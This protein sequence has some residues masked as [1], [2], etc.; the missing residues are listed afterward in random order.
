MTLGFK[1]KHFVSFLIILACIS[2]FIFK[3]F[4]KP[5]QYYTTADEGIYFERSMI[6]NE[7]GLNG[8]SKITNDFISIEQQHYT[9]NPCRYLYYMWGALFVGLSPTIDSLSILSLFCFFITGLILY[10]YIKK[11]ENEKIAFFASIIAITF[12]ISM[13]MAGRALM[14]SGNTLFCVWVLL[15]YALAVK[16]PNRNN[17]IIF[18]I[19]SL[20]SFFYKES[21]FFVAPFFALFS[22]YLIYIKK[23]QLTYRSFFYFH[24]LP[25]LIAIV[26]YILFVGGIER[27]NQVIHI[28]QTTRI[29]YVFYWGK[30][31][32]YQYLIEFSILSLA[33]MI[34]FFSSIFDFKKHSKQKHFLLLLLTFF[35]FSLIVYTFIP[36]NIRFFYNCFIVCSLFASHKLLSIK[37]SPNNKIQNVLPYIFVTIIGISHCLIYYNLFKINNMYDPTFYEIVKKFNF[38]PS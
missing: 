11:L 24:V 15:S 37:F 32:W 7:M 29:E 36:K 13:G 31:S 26:G 1:D 18:A 34:L 23:T 21:N 16:E 28:M 3:N 38:I 6:I 17:W 22:F 20:I 19:V 33:T 30:G 4:P 14:D 27:I 9:P 10:I 35:I 8:F 5:E 25:P 2:I 12:P